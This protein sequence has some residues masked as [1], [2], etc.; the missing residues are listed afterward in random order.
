MVEFRVGVECLPSGSSKVSL[1]NSGALTAG[2]C[3]GS[4]L[5]GQR[6]R[7]IE[8]PCEVDVDPPA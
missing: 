4:M 5:L 8:H 3:Y 7:Y 2:T 6:G 1:E